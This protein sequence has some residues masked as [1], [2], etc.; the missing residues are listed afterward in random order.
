MAN[1]A[2]SVILSERSSDGY[3]WH[4]FDSRRPNLLFKAMTTDSWNSEGFRA[5]KESTGNPTKVAFLFCR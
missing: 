3:E 5:V 2:N 1:Q 4:V